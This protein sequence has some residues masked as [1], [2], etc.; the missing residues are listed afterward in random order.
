MDNEQDRTP[1]EQ[2]SREETV[3]ATSWK[4]QEIL[5]N[6]YPK[7]GMR[8]R[9][10][11]ISIQGDPDPVNVARYRREGWSVVVPSE[12]PECGVDTDQDRVEI[13][14]LVLMEIAESIAQQRDDYYNRLAR[15]QTDA[16]DTQLK[17]QEDARMPTMFRE[18]SSKTTRGGG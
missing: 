6:P 2:T 9:W 18:V 12:V 7:P 10:M 17:A 1:R 11:R 13:G 16:I 4:P 8:R 3:R 5:P 15:A 14:G